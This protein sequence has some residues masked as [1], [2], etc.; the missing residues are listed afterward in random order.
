MI[1]E[2]ADAPTLLDAVID[3]LNDEVLPQLSQADTRYKTLIA[4]NVLDIVRREW[5]LGPHAVSAELAALN[6]LCGTSD[7]RLESARLALC[8]QLR[9]GDLDQQIEVIAS[10]LLPATAGRLAID[11]PRY[12]TLAALR[13][14][15]ADVGSGED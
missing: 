14:M 11:N 2:V 4:R 8:E 5:M 10:E 6:R 7:S 13:P 9:R 15:L 1:D 3:L 12:S